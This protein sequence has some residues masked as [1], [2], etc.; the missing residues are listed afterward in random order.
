MDV[1]DPTVGDRSRCGG[2]ARPHGKV[3]PETRGTT[4][5]E[6]LGLGERLGRVQGVMANS[7]VGTMPARGHQSVQ[8]TVG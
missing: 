4:T 1:R 6:L 8:N 3:S 7:I 5:V 2:A